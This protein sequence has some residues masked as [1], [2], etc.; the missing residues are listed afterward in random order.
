MMIKETVIVARSITN[1]VA[2]L[3][4]ITKNTRINMLAA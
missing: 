2:L 3:K 4:D 1:D